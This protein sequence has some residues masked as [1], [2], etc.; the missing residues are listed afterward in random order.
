MKKKWSDAYPLSKLLEGGAD[1]QKW[2][3][4]KG[5][6]VLIQHGGDIVYIGGTAKGNFGTRLM[7]HVIKLLQWKV[8]G[9]RVSAQWQ[10]YLSDRTSRIDDVSA[11]F[12][13]LN[14]E[15]SEPAENYLLQK[16]QERWNRLPK[17][18]D[19]GPGTLMCEI[20]LP[21][22]LKMSSRSA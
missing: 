15:E 14:E 10:I 5:V 18:N 21:D 13:E 22:E 20:P 12:C 2:M 8:T 19:D 9:V 4:S 11:R 1:I 17:A 6:Y 3:N 7:T 16:F